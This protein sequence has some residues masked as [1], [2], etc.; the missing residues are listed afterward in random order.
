MFRGQILL[1]MKVS[2]FF[3]AVLKVI[4]YLCSPLIRKKYL[5]KDFQD[6]DF[7]PSQCSLTC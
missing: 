5:W 6:L 2:D 3:S 7:S 1:F 4:G